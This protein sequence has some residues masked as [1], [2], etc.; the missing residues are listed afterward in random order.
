MILKSAAGHWAAQHPFNVHPSYRSSYHYSVEAPAAALRHRSARLQSLHAT[1]V[2]AQER[3][4][5]Y[6]PARAAPAGGLAACCK[7]DRPGVGRICAAAA[8]LW[9]G[10]DGGLAARPGAPERAH[11]HSLVNSPPG[12][13]APPNAPLHVRV[14]GSGPAH[15]CNRQTVNSRRCTDAAQALHRGVLGVAAAGCPP[16]HWASSP[17]PPFAEALRVPSTRLSL[18]WDGALLPCARLT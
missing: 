9:H 15:S 11:I 1:L 7:D 16:L 3:P 18:E 4:L 8:Q 17:S 6:L 10:G 14:W 5:A 13:C 12:P 2:C